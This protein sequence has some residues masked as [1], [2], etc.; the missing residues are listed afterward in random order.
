MT[1]PFGVSA[2]LASALKRF[3]IEE[4]MTVLYMPYGIE[5]DYPRVDV[6]AIGGFTS[7]GI[8][9]VVLV[10]METNEVFHSQRWEAKYRRLFG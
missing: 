4:I 5:T 6:M 3:S 8:P 10:D 9:I 7:G 1:I 2:I